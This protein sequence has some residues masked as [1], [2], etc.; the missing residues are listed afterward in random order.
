MS[1]PGNDLSG[2]DPS[3]EAVPGSY[4]DS[5]SGSLAVSDI[6]RRT[7]LIAM[8]DARLRRSLRDVDP[9]VVVRRPS[10]LP[11]WSIGHVLTHLAQ[12]AEGLRRLLTWARTGVETPMYPPSV[13]RDADVAAGALRS[14]PDILA[15]YHSASDALA[16]DIVSLPGS[17]WDTPVRTR[18]G[19]PTAAD[20]VLDHRLAEILLHHHDLGIDAGLIELPDVLAA[21]LL[22]AQPRTFL[23]THDVPP[24]TLAPRSRNGTDGPRMTIGNLG[25]GKLGIANDGTGPEITGT[26]AALVGWLTGRTDGSGLTTTTP[27]DAL[28]SLPTW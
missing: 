16:S 15:A 3:D 11:G 20:A 21:A 9:E 14:G 10:L 8:A 4:W 23:R 22:A 25:I 28:P 6:R 1:S 26:A 5:D 12:N 2:V 18:T 17:A 7:D 24:M 13:D 19:P 27:D